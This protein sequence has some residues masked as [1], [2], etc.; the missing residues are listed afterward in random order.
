M[1]FWHADDYRA[2]LKFRTDERKLY[3][4]GLTY[5]ALAA[6]CKVDKAYLSR[7]FRQEADLSQDQLYLAANC[8]GV[9]GLEREFLFTLHAYSRSALAERRNELRSVLES[10]RR[11]A[12]ETQQHIT[13]GVVG[14]DEDTVLAPYFLDPNAQLVHIFLTLD[15][16]RS[17][18]EAIGDEL[19][20]GKERLHAILE[21]LRRL[22]LIDL[23]T[24]TPRVARDSL[25]LPPSSA[26]YPAYRALARQRALE[27]MQ[28]SDPNDG[29]FFSAVFSAT[30]VEERA[31]RQR[32]LEVLT[33]SEAEIKEA[34]AEEV[35]QL[36]LDLF[37]WSGRA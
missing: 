11:R 36:S 16:F 4:S 20:I 28:A 8:L 5:G 9:A 31:I 15:R 18:P 23:S 29:Y 24:K 34:P 19:G 33:A 26:Y 37:R 32:L 10:L 1:N 6:T 17:T 35:Y 7:V 30:P 27:R 13:T 12:L 25:Y 22:G 3:V 14:P 21:L 2:A